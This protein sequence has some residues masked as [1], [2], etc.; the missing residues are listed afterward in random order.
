MFQIKNAFLFF[1]PNL[2]QDWPE[3][4]ETSALVVNMQHSPSNDRKEP[5][6]NRNIE[7]KTSSS[8]VKPTLRKN[9]ISFLFTKHLERQIEFCFVRNTF[10]VGSSSSGIRDKKIFLLQRF[11]SRKSFFF[12]WRA[13]DPSVSYQVS[14]VRQRLFSVVSNKG[15]Y[16]HV[17][18][19]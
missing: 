9:W 4:F 6:R 2:K 5:N 1:L 19:R 14:F 11:L 8:K 18:L 13:I 16:A 7:N 17:T 15:F 10:G 12:V 3:S